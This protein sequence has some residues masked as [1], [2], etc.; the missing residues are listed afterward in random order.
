MNGATQIL[1]CNL[2]GGKLRLLRRRPGEILAWQRDVRVVSQVK[3]KATRNRFSV[4]SQANDAEWNF[5]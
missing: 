5:P 3:Y 2:N 4:L 1:E